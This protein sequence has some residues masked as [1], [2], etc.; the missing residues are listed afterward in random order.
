M[1]DMKKISIIVPVHN[2]EKYIEQC[3]ESI[4]SQTYKCFELILIDDNSTDSSYAILEKYKA[5]DDRIILRHVCA[6]SAGKARNY[7]LKEANGFYLAFIDSD[8]WVEPTYLEEMILEIER[9]NCDCAICG[10]TRHFKD[11]TS[12]KRALQVKGNIASGEEMRNGTLISIMP[13]SQQ[14]P[15]FYL[16]DKVYKRSLWENVFFD[17]DLRN[18]EDRVALYSVFNDNVKTAVITTPLYNYRVCIGITSQKQKP[19]RHDDYTA[20]YKILKIATDKGYDLSPVYQSIICHTLG[21]ARKLIIEKDLAKY[22]EVACNFKKLYPSCKKII[23]NAQIEF[24]IL[25]PFFC[26]FPKCMYYGYTLLEKVK[27]ILQ[28]NKHI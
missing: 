24:K 25:A 21:M 27:Y 22:Y 26:H 19:G 16:W 17:Q 7:G 23:R 5:R 14:P 4:L 1:M 2:S 11:G 12:E 8:D 18:A 20:G 3:V 15:T 10:V 6:G 28:G 13:A 9:N